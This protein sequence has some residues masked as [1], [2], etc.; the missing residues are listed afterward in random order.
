M[1]KEKI[2]ARMP[3]R[4]G[5]RESSALQ[6]QTRIYSVIFEYQTPQ[7]TNPKGHWGPNYFFKK[8][9]FLLSPC[10]QSWYTQSYDLYEESA[11]THHHHVYRDQDK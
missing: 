3:R 9:W 5:L 8:S 10:T 1:Y 6:H 2:L 4:V 11:D 7:E